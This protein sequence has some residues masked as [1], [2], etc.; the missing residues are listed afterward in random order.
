MIQPLAT[1]KDTA[2]LNTDG[3]ERSSCAAFTINSHD[4]WGASRHAEDIADILHELCEEMLVE[5]LAGWF[6]DTTTW[7]P[8]RNFDV[9]CRWF[10]Y[11][12]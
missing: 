5:Q 11:Q 4:I 9:F 6:N 7:P 12:H 10:D 2:M 8:D 3:S 1:A